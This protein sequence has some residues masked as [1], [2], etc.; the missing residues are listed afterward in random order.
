MEREKI[1]NG[2]RVGEYKMNNEEFYKQFEQKY[3]E[4]MNY[5]GISTFPPDAPNGGEI[6]QEN[7][8]EWAKYLSDRK[9]Y[10]YFNG[11]DVSDLFGCTL[12]ACEFKAIDKDV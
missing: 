10:F 2:F 4:G 9:V 5:V 7:Y 12:D 8:L 6:T 3:C 1:F 11:G